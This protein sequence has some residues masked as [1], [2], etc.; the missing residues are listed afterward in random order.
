MIDIE[1]ELRDLLDQ[2]G[3]YYDGGVLAQLARPIQEHIEE[4]HDELT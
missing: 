3:F 4:L 2:A 1:Q